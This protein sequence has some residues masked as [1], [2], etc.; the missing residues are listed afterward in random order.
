MTSQQTG[1][2]HEVDL[3]RLLRVLWRRR[4]VLAGTIAGSLL[5]ALAV[6]SQIT[7]LYTAQTLVMLNTRAARIVEV[8]E[9]VPTLPVDSPA[10][11][12]EM[13]VLRS[14][15]L[16]EAVVSA[17]TL[18]ADPEFNPTLSPPPW[19]L[20]LLQAIGLTA[21][22]SAPVLEQTIETFRE[23]VSVGVLDRSLVL[24]VRVKAETPEKAAF[25]S[26][27]MAEIYLDRQRDA[28]VLATREA[29]DWL[30]VRLDDLR[31][32]VTAAEADISAYRTAHN[33]GQDADGPATR[34]QR[35]GINAELIAARATRAEMEARLA[36]LREAAARNQLDAASEVLSSPL[37]Q[38]LREQESTVSRQLDDLATRYGDKHP[39]MIETRAELDGLQQGIAREA[40][41]IAAAL[42]SDVRAVRARENTL[43]RAL[44]DIEARRS[45]EGE[46]TLR[47]V[48]L[49]RRAAAARSLYESFLSRYQEAAGQI[50]IQ[51]AD[52]T[53]VSAA[54]LPIRPAYPRKGLTLAAVALVSTLIALVLIYGLEHLNRALRLPEDVE[55]RLGRPCLGQVPFAAGA[56]ASGL[57]SPAAEEEMRTLRT[58]ITLST[59]NG[60]PPG[61]IC[62]TSSLP[63]E[64]KTTLALWLARTLASRPRGAVLIDCDLR[65][66]R[67]ADITG[68]PARP[69]L[70]DLLAG[71]AGL[72]DVLHPG[73]VDGLMILPGRAIGGAAPDVLAGPAM[74]DLL[75]T[76]REHFDTIL[77][78]TPPV[79]PVADARMLAPLA[80]TLLYAV[81][82]EKTPYDVAAQGLSRLTEGGSPAPGIVLTRVDTRRQ[83]SYGYGGH[84]RY[85]G[86]YETC[87]DR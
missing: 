7:P 67:L 73:P 47:L 9:V 20:A 23:A 36:R 79:L 11:R 70:A 37:I 3:D 80:D 17:E 44:E 83:A 62:I 46:A 41:K 75:A 35:T 49:E 5:I 53:I 40:D 69:G 74:R 58:A 28:K 1:T 34:Q 66:P 26:R 12:S 39:R 68:C 72:A 2:L 51:A 21:P 24:A 18:I 38:R 57:P 14:R 60:S 4:G 22:G 65:R 30:L 77:L 78:D 86:H 32:S 59:P 31:R 82:W 84:A 42:A 63:E 56:N 45:D 19:P 52:G 43:V 87:Q 27:R 29:A 48:E 25:L 15:A 55:A 16:A 50:G 64:G 13:E 71:D 33:L 8:T 81:R 10:V 61:I 85:Y 54:A 6:L 76:L